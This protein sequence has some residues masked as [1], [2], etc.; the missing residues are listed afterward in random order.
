MLAF[1]PFFLWKSGIKEPEPQST[2]GKLFVVLLLPLL[3][4]EGWGE[5]LLGW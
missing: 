2:G 3:L 1:I 4:G 5:G